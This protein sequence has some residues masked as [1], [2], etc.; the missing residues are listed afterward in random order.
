[1]ALNQVAQESI[2]TAYVTASEELLKGEAILIKGCKT[3]L[4]GDNIQIR[5]T[6]EVSIDPDLDVYDWDGGAMPIVQTPQDTKVKIAID[7]GKYARVQINSADFAFLNGMAGTPEKQLSAQGKYGKRLAYKMVVAK[8]QEIA[9]LY[10]RA[11]LG[12]SYGAGTCSDSNP[13]HANENNAEQ[14]IANIANTFNNNLVSTS[15]NKINVY[16]PPSFATLLG[17]QSGNDNTAEGRT[18][19]L[20]R[21]VARRNNMNIYES[22]FLTSTNVDGGLGYRI[23][24]FVDKEA[25]AFGQNREIFDDLVIDIVNDSVTRQLKCTA[26]YGAGAYRADKVLTLTVVC[27]NLTM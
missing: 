25:I 2:K 6:I 3:N 19:R 7:K 9:G 23:L 16:I 14:I 4:T 15:T 1:M 12:V 24:A 10:A 5:D 20:G 26:I 11:G 21:F 17:F 22:N 13:I 27:D 8:E 18:E